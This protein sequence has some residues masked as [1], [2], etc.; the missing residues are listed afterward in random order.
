MSACTHM[1]SSVFVKQD[2]KTTLKTSTS[3][4]A[5]V[6]FSSYMRSVVTSGFENVR[7]GTFSKDR[8]VLLY[9]HFGLALS[10]ESLLI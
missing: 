4:W 1:Y 6:S 2:S 3:T 7:K 5:V 9:F 8:F 10:V